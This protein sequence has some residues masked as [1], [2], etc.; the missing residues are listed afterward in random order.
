MKK[1]LVAIDGSVFAQRALD[2]AIELSVRAQAELHILTVPQIV[3]DPELDKFCKIE[4]LTM[5]DLMEHEANGLLSRAK[6]Q[7]SQNGTESTTTIVAAGD[8]AE[9]ILNYAKNC[10]ADLIVLGKR[11]RGRL[12]GLLLGS[13]SQ[14]IAIL[15]DRPVL[16]VP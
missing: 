16:I 8:P 13:V 3:P 12:A 14:K 5:G 1:I 9:A 6:Q 15:A 11:G 10:L 7:A 2:V 4:N